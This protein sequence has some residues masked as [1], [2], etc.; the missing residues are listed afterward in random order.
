MCVVLLR[1][2]PKQKRSVM[3]IAHPHLAGVALGFMLRWKAWPDEWV[4]PA[5]RRP[6]TP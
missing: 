4:E 3:D 6:Q 2:C 1:N 5:T